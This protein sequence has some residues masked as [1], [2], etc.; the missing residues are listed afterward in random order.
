MQLQGNEAPYDGTCKLTFNNTEATKG[1]ALQTEFILFVDNWKD[2]DDEISQ[3]KYRV[4]GKWQLA[5][6]QSGN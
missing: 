3:A 5:E 4:Y 6:C 2:D 1:K